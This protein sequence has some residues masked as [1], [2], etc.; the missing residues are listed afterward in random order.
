MPLYVL[1]C[2]QGIMILIYGFLQDIYIHIHL[3]FEQKV[4]IFNTIRNRNNNK[5]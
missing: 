1:F 3:N 2:S 4:N 5:N